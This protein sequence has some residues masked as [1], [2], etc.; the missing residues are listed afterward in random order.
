MQSSIEEKR[1]SRQTILP[2][3]GH[4]GQKKLA[5]AKVFVLGSGGLASAAAFY[6]TAAGVGKIGIAD[7]DRV[8]ISNLNR[9]ILHD[10][11]R[12]GILKVDSAKKSL[13]ALYPELEI[14]TFPRRIDASREI[15]EILSGYD[16]V[17]D[18]TDNFAAR[19]RINT[20]CLQMGKPWIYGAVLGF[21]GQVMT[22]VPGKGPC[23]QCL[24]PSGRADAPAV[25]AVMG[26]SAGVIGVLQAAEAIKCILKKGTLLL[27]KMLF[28]DLMEM[29]FSEFRITRNSN[30]PACGAL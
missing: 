11:S 23:Y 12:I 29:N 6:L 8:D 20:A 1:F 30:C 3:V 14:E 24:Y 19:Y 4:E 13:Q 25:A 28:V 7:D 16:L 21:E 5:D 15:M 9:Q 2:E 17:I 27:G 18:C 22:V 26:V 10:T